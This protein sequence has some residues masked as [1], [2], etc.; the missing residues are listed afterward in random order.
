LEFLSLKSVTFRMRIRPIQI[1][2]VGIVD[3]RLP[4]FA[5]RYWS[6]GQLGQQSEKA[7]V[8][9]EVVHPSTAV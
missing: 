9:V 7:K 8:R 4:R 3:Q 2:V 6:L 1:V 5:L